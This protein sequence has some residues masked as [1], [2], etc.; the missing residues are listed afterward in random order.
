V[1]F[2]FAS[3][4]ITQNYVPAVQEVP[5]V[6]ARAGTVNTAGT[7]N[8]A[9]NGGFE[10][11]T[12]TNAVRP[13]IRLMRNPIVTGAGHYVT[14]NADGG[15]PAPTSPQRVNANT[16]VA[17]PATM[18]RDG[19]RFVRWENAAAPGVAFNF[20][21]NITQAITLNAIWQRVH[22]VTF[23]LNGGTSAQ[24]DQQTVDDTTGRVT[25]PGNPT[26]PGYTFTRWENTATPGTAF[27]WATTPVTADITIRAIWTANTGTVNFSLNGG[28]GTPPA[29]FTATTGGTW[30]A[31][32]TVPANIARI[33][34]LLM[35]FATAPTDGQMVFNRYGQLVAGYPPL[36][37][38]AGGITLYAQWVPT[39]G[40]FGL[41]ELIAEALSRN[42]QPSD[43]DT[44]TEWEALAV[45]LY[46]GQWAL[47]YLPNLSPQQVES[48]ALQLRKAMEGAN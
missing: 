13:A 41:A 43:F 12:T 8:A 10:V 39:T 26:R 38:L 23:D 6:N 19:Y 37:M 24:P 16:P 14:F 15:T 27:P 11:M 9:A 35:G 42:F 36:V 1:Q 46:R 2:A 45:A 29:T 7:V 21:T 22:T 31:S 18:T 33:G 47:S 5:A 40:G 44:V 25:N 4:L 28:T 34:H 17:E 48:I 30:P 20:A 32:I 3:W